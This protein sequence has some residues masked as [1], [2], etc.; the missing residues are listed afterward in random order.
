M[1]HV[2]VAVVLPKGQLA[3][4]E[5][6]WRT[7]RAH[8]RDHDITWVESFK[9]CATVIFAVIEYIQLVEKETA[10]KQYMRHN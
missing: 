4:F 3:L 1:P 8:A 10:D 5:V 6:Q 9:M 7:G 2:L